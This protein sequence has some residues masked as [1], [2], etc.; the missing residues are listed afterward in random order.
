MDVLLLQ[1]AQ[2]YIVSKLDGEINNA[3]ASKVLVLL[4]EFCENSLSSM[5]LSGA[6]KAFL[7][8][9]WLKTFIPS[10][11]DAEVAMCSQF[12]ERLIEA[13]LG[14]FMINVKASVATT[15]VTSSVVPAVASVTS[16]VVPAVVT[17]SSGTIGRSKSK[18]W[19][20][21]SSCVN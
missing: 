18:F 16:S 2:A 20:K 14:K 15:A 10:L 12:L 5:N 17:T 4:C 7:S 1:R 11:T 8:M 13:T 19:M 3:N 9:T 6:E 21:P